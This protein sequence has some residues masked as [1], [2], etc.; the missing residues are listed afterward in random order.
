MKNYKGAQGAVLKLDKGIKNLQIG[1]NSLI[2]C[3]VLVA[4]IFDFCTFLL[5]CSKPKLCEIFLGTFLGFKLA[6]FGVLV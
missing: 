5:H 1:M 4:E 6:V 2:K 3:G